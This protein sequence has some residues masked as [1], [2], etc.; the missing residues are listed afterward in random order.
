[1]AWR[2][3]GAKRPSHSFTCFP[4]NSDPLWV[5]RE[6]KSRSVEGKPRQSML[7]CPKID[8]KPHHL[9]KRDTSPLCEPGSTCTCWERDVQCRSELFQLPTLHPGLKWNHCLW[10][11]LTRAG[12][13]SFSLKCS[14]GRSTCSHMR[15]RALQ[16]V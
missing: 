14:R 12:K 16:P 8:W 6:G 5:T 11:L 13:L 10:E 2:L 15:S 9:G 7:G 3:R 4:T 1:M